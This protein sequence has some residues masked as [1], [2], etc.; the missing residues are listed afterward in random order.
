MSIEDRNFT[1]WVDGAFV[2]WD[3]ATTHL[4]SHTMQHGTGVF[5]GV[6]AYRTRRGGAVFRLQDHTDRLFDS[7]HML[8]L[9]I[10]Y[11][12]ADLNSVHLQLMRR[13]GFGECYFRPM[14][15]LGGES[16]G[17]SAFKNSV[18][19]A[20][21]AWPWRDYHGP[22]STE[23]GLSLMTSSF[24]RLHHNSVFLKAKANGHY[25]NS[26]MANMEAKR[27]GFDDALMLDAHGF[28]AE[29]STSNIFVVRK[30]EIA[31][32]CRSSVLEG[33]TRETIIH[34]ARDRGREVVERNITREEVYRADEVF[35]TGTA[36]EIVPLVSLDGRK[37]GDGYPGK[38]TRNLQARFREIVT[39]EVEAYRSW[40]TFAN[41]ERENVAPIPGT[42]SEG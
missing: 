6:R 19:V 39:G 33:I 5:E 34:L 15:F 11:D 35:L 17:V 1:A 7:A 14:V 38:L 3:E 28:V 37:V 9:T 12:K 21:L 24:S 40:L 18:H 23:K 32:P 27:A 29:A 41:P 16:V 36:A 20:I 2:P 30:D 10:P 4:L 13:N 42:G 26:T 25:I 31:T 22:R 8:G